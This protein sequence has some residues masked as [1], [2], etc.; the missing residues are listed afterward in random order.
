VEDVNGKISSPSKG[1]AREVNED[2]IRE[3]VPA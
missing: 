3:S 2:E 1:K